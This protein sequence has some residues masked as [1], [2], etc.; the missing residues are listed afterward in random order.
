MAGFAA[1]LKDHS[2]IHGLQPKVLPLCFVNGNDNQRPLT[3]PAVHELLE[4]SLLAPLRQAVAAE[5]GVDGVLLS[6]HGS[7]C[8]EGDDDVDGTVLYRVREIGQFTSNLLG[9]GCL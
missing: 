6:L 3:A 1:G 5:G 2:L 9:A 8:A 7:F 4:T